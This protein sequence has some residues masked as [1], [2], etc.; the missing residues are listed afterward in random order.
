MTHV[1]SLTRR[2]PLIRHSRIIMKAR[3]TR[4][5]VI[6]MNTMRVKIQCESRMER[7]PSRGTS[8]RDLSALR[9][10]MRFFTFA[11][12]NRAPSRFCNPPSPI[13]LIQ[14]PEGEVVIS[15]SAVFALPE[16]SLVPSEAHDDAHLPSGFDTLLDFMSIRHSK[17]KLSAWLACCAG[18]QNNQP[19]VAPRGGRHEGWLRAAPRRDAGRK[20]KG[21]SPVGDVARSG[22]GGGGGGGRG[23]V[24]SARARKHRAPTSIIVPRLKT[25]RAPLSSNS[26]RSP[27]D[28]GTITPRG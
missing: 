12:A 4:A 9:H 8:A 10:F 13:S 7:H 11:M 2:T 6:F 28:K 1:R 15:S 22:W 17:V 24:A 26:L 25:D 16:P 21:T 5:F 19:R 3:I 14:M 20:G 18:R 27:I 23:W